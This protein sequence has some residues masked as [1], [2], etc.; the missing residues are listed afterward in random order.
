MFGEQ[1][2]LVRATVSDLGPLL[3]TRMLNLNDT[4]AGVLQLVFK[5]ADDR[6]ILL[7]DMKDSGPCA[8]MW[9]KTP[10]GIHHRIRQTSAHGQHRS[11]SAGH[12]CR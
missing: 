8:S 3:L 12:C 4:Q 11:H 6:G 2:H 1:G 9:A 7:L 10:K 5:I